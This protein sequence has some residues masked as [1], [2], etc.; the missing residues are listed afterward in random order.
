MADR[1]RRGADSG[2]RHV[3]HLETN[4]A[5]NDLV[6]DAAS[7]AALDAAFPPGTTV[8]ERHPVQRPIAQPVT[9][10]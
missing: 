4:L 5:A 2:T 6:L 3:A 1:A 8:G 9:A 7:L 10:R